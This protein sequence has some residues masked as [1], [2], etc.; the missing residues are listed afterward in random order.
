MNFVQILCKLCAYLAIGV[1]A[2]TARVHPVGPVLAQDKHT[3]IKASHATTLLTQGQ[4]EL[5]KDEALHFV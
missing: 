4:Y 3:N 5:N 2:Q 1:R